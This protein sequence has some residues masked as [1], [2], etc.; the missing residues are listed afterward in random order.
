MLSLGHSDLQN[1]SASDKIFLYD[2]FVL[3]ES[4]LVVYHKPLNETIDNGG[5]I[6]AQ[7]HVRRQNSKVTYPTQD[8]VLEVEQQLSKVALDTN[9]IRLGLELTLKHIKSQLR[10]DMLLR[11]LMKRSQVAA[12]VGLGIRIELR[13]LLVEDER[14]V[15]RQ[16]LHPQAL[17]EVNRVLFVVEC[18]FCLKKESC[19]DSYTRY[20]I[21]RI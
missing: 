15:L 11:S 1:Y 8:V 17:V 6:Q 12:L 21:T 7:T 4:I 16:P 2:Q 20:T 3:I 18:S 10:R 13:A 19:S 14:V 5:T 9:P